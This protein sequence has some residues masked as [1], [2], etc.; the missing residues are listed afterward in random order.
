MRTELPVLAPAQKLDI[1][2]LRY[3]SEN[4]FLGIIIGFN[5]LVFLA[6]GVACFFQPTILLYVGGGTLFIYLLSKLEWLLAYWFL[7][8][9]SVKVSEAQYPE[10]H[11]AVR[12]A[13]GYID[14][15]PYPT[16]FVLSG[17]GLL[18]IFVAKRFSKKG[19]LIFTSELVDNLLD[20]GDSR[21]LMMLIG[22]QLGHIKAGH[23]KGWF[24]KDVIGAF[25]FVINLAWWRRCHY[26]ADRVGFLVA[27]NLEASRRALLTLT[28]GKKL[29]QATRM[30]ALQEQ[31]DDL[32]SSFFAWLS[33]VLQRYPFIIRR[34]IELESFQ[35]RVLERPYSVAAREEVA[36]LPADVSR[37]QIIN[38]TGQAI[39]GDRG[40]ISV[41]PA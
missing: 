25:T 16:V 32:D 36:A 21:Q 23:F 14:L 41:Q 39:F 8:G 20:S 28:V 15:K 6:L 13:C 40:S 12:L 34:I 17:N 10:I 2:S 11:R 35:G 18:E 37:F 7:Y 24:F 29:A 38:I 5:C 33:Q 4:T 26:T 31:E 9:N 19:L 27:G 22:R 30:E 3:P 1:E